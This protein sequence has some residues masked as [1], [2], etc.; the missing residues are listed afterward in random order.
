M[1]R[2]PPRSKRT[3]TLFPYTTLFRSPFRK[4]AG[5]IKAI[6]SLEDGTGKIVEEAVIPRGSEILVLRGQ[7]GAVRIVEQQR[8]IAAILGEVGAEVTREIG[9]ASCRERGCQYV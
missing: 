8:D 7:C 5:V 1:I 9:R 2:R 4:R 6:R 3:D